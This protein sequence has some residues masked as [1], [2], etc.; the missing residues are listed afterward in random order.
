M[1]G[2]VTQWYNY[3]VF[4][5]SIIIVIM[6]YNVLFSILLVGHRPP[7]ILGLAL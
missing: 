5:N 1:K 4:T 6:Y 2:I 7:C 3:D